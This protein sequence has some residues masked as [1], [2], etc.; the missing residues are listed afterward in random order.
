MVCSF[1]TLVGECF[2][3]I[4]TFMTEWTHTVRLLISRVEKSHYKYKVNSSPSHMFSQAQTPRTEIMFS[5]LV[6]NV[7]LRSVAWCKW[8]QQMDG[9]SSKT[10]LTP[11]R[12]GMYGGEKQWWDGSKNEG[13][14]AV[15]KWRRRPMLLHHHHVSGWHAAVCWL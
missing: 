6:S 12:R 2:W 3:H 8:N 10:S 14:F 11:Q 4:S 15:K 1:E 13:K 5:S 9:T 7:T